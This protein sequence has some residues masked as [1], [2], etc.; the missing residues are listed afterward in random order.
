MPL[1]SA[2]RQVGMDFV[3]QI[4]WPI[5]DGQNVLATTDN[6]CPPPDGWVWTKSTRHKG[7]LCHQTGIDFVIQIVLHRERLFTGRLF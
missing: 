5:H 1:V 7:W 2:I 6:E 3:N 4:G